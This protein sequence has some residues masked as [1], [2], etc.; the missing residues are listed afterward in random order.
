MKETIN[1]RQSALDYRRWA[2]SAG[3]HSKL[4]KFYFRKAQALDVALYQEVESIRPVRK[5]EY[6]TAKVKLFEY[7]DKGEEEIFLG[8]KRPYINDQ[9]VRE[10]LI[11]AGYTQLGIQPRWCYHKGFKRA[12][13]GP[14]TAVQFRLGED[15]RYGYQPGWHGVDELPTL[16]KNNPPDFEEG[17]DILRAR[18]L[19]S[20]D[21]FQELKKE[22][23]KAGRRWLYLD[24]WT[25]DAE[26]DIIRF[27]LNPRP[28]DIY[29]CGTY[30]IDELRLWLD[31]QGPVTKRRK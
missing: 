15:N 21:D 31:D 6:E 28:P 2:D 22:L 8:E 9:K 3:S 7:I 24:A 17:A 25:Y 14:Q 20:L 30:T 12:K 13:N 23:I 19:K 11:E 27:I 29:E 26:E 16:M 1:S 18:F 10:L 4:G 5:G